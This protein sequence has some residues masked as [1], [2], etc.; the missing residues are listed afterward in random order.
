MIVD[1]KKFIV[2]G[3]L[4]RKAVLAHVTEHLLTQNHRVE[5][6]DENGDEH[7]LYRGEEGTS[8]AIGCMIPDERYTSDLE[9][10]LVSSSRIQIAA[11]GSTLGDS[12]WRWLSKLQYVHDHAHTNEWSV[13]LQEL[14]KGL[15]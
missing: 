2:D 13:R 14:A 6:I 12:E 5:S 11:F 7:C 15:S 1:G 10:L 4:D 9:N 3:K 8:C